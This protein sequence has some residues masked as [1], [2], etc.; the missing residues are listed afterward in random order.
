MGGELTGPAAGLSVAA[1]ALRDPGGLGEP[2]AGL[3]RLQVIKL[4]L[5]ASDAVHEAVVDIAGKPGGGGVDTRSCETTGVGADQLC[6]VWRDP[7][8]DPARPALYY[9]RV[10]ENP[11]CRWSTWVCNAAGVVCGDPD[12][13]GDGFEP[14]CDPDFPKTI[15]ERAWSSPIWYHPK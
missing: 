10:V 11:T 4:W 12:S 7:V 14:C 2:G 5:D 9:T 13:I 1:F 15:Q 6:A 3:Q 8:F